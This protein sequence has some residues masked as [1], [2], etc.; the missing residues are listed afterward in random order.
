MKSSITFYTHMD[1]Y[2]IFYITGRCGRA[3]LPSLLQREIYDSRISVLWLHL[4]VHGILYD[5]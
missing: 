2:H 4:T 1:P 3:L 5:Y